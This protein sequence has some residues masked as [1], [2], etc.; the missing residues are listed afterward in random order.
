MIL[1]SFAD[2]AKRCRL[3]RIVSLRPPGACDA[4]A[5]NL[6]EDRCSWV[7][8]RYRAFWLELAS[9]ERSGILYSQLQGL[10]ATRRVTNDRLSEGLRREKL[11]PILVEIYAIPDKD[12][13]VLAVPV[14]RNGLKGVAEYGV[15]EP[16]IH[17]SKLTPE[18]SRAA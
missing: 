4:N 17:L 15:E 6:Q 5:V 7:G 10:A 12:V 18:L 16:T 1:A 8:D 2:A 3:E 13:L 14:P 9:D 11:K